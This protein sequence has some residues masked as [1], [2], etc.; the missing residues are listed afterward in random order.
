MSIF[1]AILGV[2]LCFIGV[3]G[4]ASGEASEAAVFLA[5][6]MVSF[7]MSY[8]VYASQKGGSNESS[9]PP[10]NI[11]QNKPSDIAKPKKERKSNKTS[12]ILIAIG[13]AT[14]VYAASTAVQ[15]AK[16][17]MGIV[18]IIFL[19]AGIVLILV[20]YGMRFTVDTS[21]EITSNN[22]S[23]AEYIQ[24]LKE[25]L[26]IARSQMISELNKIDK[27]YML[28][29]SKAD[30]VAITSSDNIPAA[31]RNRIKPGPPTVSEYYSNM[32][33]IFESLYQ[34]MPMTDEQA[35]DVVSAFVFEL[36]P[37]ITDEKLREI[38]F[39]FGKYVHKDFPFLKDKINYELG[40]L[41]VI[42]TVAQRNNDLNLYQKV[43]AIRKKRGYID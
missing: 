29:L 23:Q 32:E 20:G 33:K 13:A 30:Y 24:N 26:A 43:Q 9:T 1:L 16:E 37:E 19:I 5:I 11:P 34:E 4:I 15:N 10:P 21:S 3:V 18:T 38:A 17:D 8:V 22:S 35:K 36:M 7:F 27:A 40:A 28:N 31:L 42:M 25:Q 12:K 6:G 2:V 14:L 39:E 41:G